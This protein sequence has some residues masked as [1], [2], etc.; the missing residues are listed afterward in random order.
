MILLDT[1]ELGIPMM[2]IAFIVWSATRR[3]SS[4]QLYQ[5]K[6]FRELRVQ[7]EAD[8]D[9]LVR[10]AHEQFLKKRENPLEA[11]TVPEEDMGALLARTK[12]DERV[13]TVNL[14]EF[15]HYAEP[16]HIRGEIL[17]F[18]LLKRTREP[19]I[20]SLTISDELGYRDAGAQPTNTRRCG[21]DYCESVREHMAREDALRIEEE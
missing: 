1:L 14:A 15:K 11:D 10:L 19:H 18:G 2:I 6:L 12:I 9:A 21:C 20:V 17:I 16:I 8:R 3:S 7:R 5:E 4:S 13:A